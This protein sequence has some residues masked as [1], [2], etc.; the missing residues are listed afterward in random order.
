MEES[1]YAH[2]GPDL[3]YSENFDTLMEVQV[4][5][6]AKLG[7]VLDK[8]SKELKKPIEELRMWPME[9]RDNGTYRPTY[10]C[11]WNDRNGTIKEI[12]KN[13]PDSVKLEVY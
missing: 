1:F 2:D 13:A 10:Q 4:K 7:D 11:Q 6:T 3:M 8:L 12:A 9:L 5:K